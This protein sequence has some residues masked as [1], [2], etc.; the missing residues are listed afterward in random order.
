MFMLMS[1]L[2]LISGKSSWVASVSWGGKAYPS[3]SALAGE[4][5]F[6]GRS[7]P[8]PLHGMESTS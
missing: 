1:Y 3:L 4:I 6:I 7:G 2:N 5:V 8:L